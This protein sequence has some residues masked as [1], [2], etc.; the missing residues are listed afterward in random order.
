[1]RAVIPLIEAADDADRPR[2]R[3]PYPEAGARADDCIQVT[4]AVTATE[5]DKFP[6]V[7]GAHLA[8]PIC[9]AGTVQT[10]TLLNDNMEV[11]NGNWTSAPAGR[12]GYFTGSSQSGARSVHARGECGHGGHHRS[13]VASGWGSPVSA[14]RAA[15]TSW[16]VART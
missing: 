3:R 10:S 13:C 12:W 4:K 2:I 9:D 16:V 6:T 11:T 5:M 14:A 7:A 1:M 8:A 15:A